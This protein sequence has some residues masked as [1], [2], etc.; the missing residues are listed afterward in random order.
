MLAKALRMGKDHMDYQKNVYILTSHFDHQNGFVISL[1]LPLETEINAER[2]GRKEKENK[3][4]LTPLAELAVF[5]LR[6]L[7]AVVY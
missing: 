5:Q 1:F 2:K 6:I 4:L 3:L 7:L